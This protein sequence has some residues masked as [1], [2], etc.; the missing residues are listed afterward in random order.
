MIRMASVSGGNH[1]ILRGICVGEETW[2]EEGETGEA[3]YL[4]NACE[5]TWDSA[6]DWLGLA[7]I[8]FHLCLEI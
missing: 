8:S 3:H 7:V 4:F 2:G 6:A 5:P 1:N